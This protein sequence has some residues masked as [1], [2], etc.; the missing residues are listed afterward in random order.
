MANPLPY[1]ISGGTILE[2]GVMFL[3]FGMLSLLPDLHG[4]VPAQVIWGCFIAGGL[5]T[6]VGSILFLIGLVKY[7]NR[8]E[9]KM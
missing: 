1:F 4:S 9:V 2:F 6:A 8:F 7:R 5:F 3:L